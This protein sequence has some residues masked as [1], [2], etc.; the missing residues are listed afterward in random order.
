MATKTYPTFHICGKYDGS[1]PAIR[2]L[3]QLHGELGSHYTLVTADFIDKEKEPNAKDIEEFKQAVTK[4]FP[5]KKVESDVGNV[6]EDIQNLQQELNE[7][8][9]SY[10]ERA[11]EL[12]RR[13]NGRDEGD[14]NAPLS[15]LEKNNSLNNN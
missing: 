3:N 14:E 5:R 12:L 13:S 6:Q 4:R 15:I 2:W 7:S 1:I 11:Q 10:H 8:L 9:D